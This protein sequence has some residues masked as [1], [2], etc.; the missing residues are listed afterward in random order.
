MPI[1]EYQC[2]QCGHHL[3]VLQKIA[4]EPLV[5][6]P[7]CG[8]ASLHKQVSAAAFR[9]KGTGWYETDFKHSGKDKDKGKADTKD[10]ADTKGKADGKDGSKDAAS[11]DKSTPAKSE[12]GSDKQSG[13]ANKGGASTGSSTSD[14]A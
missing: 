7:E 3:E 14:S 9:L 1:Y 6:C 13:G 4:D 5:Y 10:K 2:D 12:S 8:D 11:T